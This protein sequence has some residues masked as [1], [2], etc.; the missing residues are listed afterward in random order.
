MAAAVGA[1]AGLV[2]FAAS[3]QALCPGSTVRFI[4]PFPGSG[5]SAD[6]IARAV[7]AKLGEAW[8]KNVIVDNRPGAGGVAANQ[9]VAAAS[10]DGCT[11][12]LVTAAIGINPALM[13]KKLPYDTLKDL[14]MLGVM[15][16]V[17]LG[18]FAHASLPA[19]TVPELIALAKAQPGSMTYATPGVGTGS[20]LAGEL[21]AHKTGTQLLHVPYKNAA[22]AELDLLAGRVS[23]MFAAVSS[24]VEQVKAGRLRLVAVTGDK[25][26]A[27]FPDVPAIGES[28]PGYSMGSYFG[29][30]GPGGMDKALA[31]RISLD[32]AQALQTPELQ[33]QLAARQLVAVGSSPEAFERLVRKEMQEMGKLVESAGIRID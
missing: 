1:A 5:S 32:I 31:G 8:G 7:A 11:I 22:S 24:E 6:G 25:R 21:L 33:R 18:L 9:L 3:A 26:L 4:V 14:T 29:V 27:G 12:A 28:V 10:P 17:P 30:I 13:K 16:D 19:K 20:H 23:L 15:V 2:P